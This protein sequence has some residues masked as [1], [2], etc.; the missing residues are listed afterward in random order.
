MWTLLAFISALCLG[1]YDVSKKIAL[2]DLPVI[3]VLTFSILFSSAIL[4]VPLALSP[5]FPETLAGA[6]L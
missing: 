6:L 4:A 2:H 3:S 5:Y 1:F